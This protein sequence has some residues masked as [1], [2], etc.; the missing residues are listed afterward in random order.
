M[1]KLNSKRNKRK[2]KTDNFEAIENIVL[3]EKAMQNLSHNYHELSKSTQLTK[4]LFYDCDNPMNITT[5]EA[6]EYI[7]LWLI[8]NTSK[9]IHLQRLNA[10][11]DKMRES[12]LYRRKISIN[13]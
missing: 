1:Q 11:G 2:K 6:K 13:F 7:K 4:N 10:S 9:T 5:P 12:K 3:Q 8:W